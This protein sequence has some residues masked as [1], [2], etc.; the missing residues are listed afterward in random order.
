[1]KEKVQAYRGHCQVGQ[2]RESTELQRALPGRSRNRKYW[3]TEGTV[4]YAKKEKVLAYRG[5][6]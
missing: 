1:M 2:E 4:R 3:P 5:S 6:C